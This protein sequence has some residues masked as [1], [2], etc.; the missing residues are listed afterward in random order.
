MLLK[1]CGTLVYAIDLLCA[2]NGTSS[3]SASSAIGGTSERVV[4][5]L[6]V[7]NVTGYGL[8]VLR[9]LLGQLTAAGIVIPL[10]THTAPS[11]ATCVTYCISYSNMHT[12]HFLCT[13]AAAFA[14]IH[15]R[16]AVCVLM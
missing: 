9:A 7:S 3:S 14:H 10:T 13:L 4:P 16:C 11:I 15:S 12:L 6:C 2:G 1:L 5:L 8:D